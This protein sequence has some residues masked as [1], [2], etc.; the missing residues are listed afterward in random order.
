MKRSYCYRVFRTSN[1]RWSFTGV[2]VTA[3]P[4]QVSRTLLSSLTNLKKN[5]VVW[6]VPMLYLIYNSL[7]VFTIPS[8]PITIGISVNRMLSNFFSPL[9]RS[10]YFYLYCNIHHYFLHIVDCYTPKVSAAV[11]SGNL[12]RIS[13]L[14]YLIYSGGEQTSLIRPS[15][16]W[17]YFASARFCL[18]SIVQ[19]LGSYTPVF[20]DI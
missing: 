6:I 11:L 12:S 15:I 4:S 1:N 3:K 14:T 2:R 9:A 17:E 13:N 7:G 16:P 18:F 5:P 10:R 20:K 8:T 19:R